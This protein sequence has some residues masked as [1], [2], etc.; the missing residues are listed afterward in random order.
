MIAKIK[1]SRIHILTLNDIAKDTWVNHPKNLKEIAVQHID[2][3][4]TTTH[5]SSTLLTPFSSDIGI[6]KLA[7]DFL[8]PKPTFEEIE[9]F[10]FNMDPMKCPGP[11]G[12]QPLFILD[13]GIL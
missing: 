1:L 9:Q 6:P 8:T 11:N 5:V 10:P 3:I 7:H 4:F 13:I 2:K 12:I